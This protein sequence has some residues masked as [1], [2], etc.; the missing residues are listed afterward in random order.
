MTAEEI[1]CDLFDK[2]G[3]DFNWYM[4]PLSQS[5]GAFVEELKK[6]I[7]E[8]H[9]LYHNKLWAVAKC[10]S[11]DNVL[12]VAG[13]ETGRDKSYASFAF[14][15]KNSRISSEDSQPSVSPDLRTF[16]SSFRSCSVAWLFS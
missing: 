13:E 2:Y 10:T 12:Y 3:E 6:E 9:I 15:R 4:V 5:N 8:G 14:F 11:N 7:G 1:F 16:D